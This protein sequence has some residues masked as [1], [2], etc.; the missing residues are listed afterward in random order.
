MKLQTIA[1]LIGFLIALAV[2][3]QSEQNQVGIEDAKKL[4]TAN[5]FSKMVLSEV[6]NHILK[7]AE[8]DR[9]KNIQTYSQ[10]EFSINSGL[11][12]VIGNFILAE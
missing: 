8:A 7:N 12:E 11:V 10:P 9:T 4:R 3:G 6:M 5:S 1:F 2:F